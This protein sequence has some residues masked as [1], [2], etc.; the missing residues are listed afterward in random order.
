MNLHFSWESSKQYEACWLQAVLWERL[1]F[2]K[3]EAVV[4]TEVLSLIGMEESA[5]HA[6]QLYLPL[7][8]RDWT[9]MHHQGV[10]SKAGLL[11]AAALTQSSLE[12]GVT[13]FQPLSDAGAAALWS[14][15]EQVAA[16][17]S[18]PGQVSLQKAHVRRLL[19]QLQLK[20][21]GLLG[22][23]ISHSCWASTM[24]CYRLTVLV[25]KH[26]S[27]LLVCIVYSVGS[28][29]AGSK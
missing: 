26:K 13:A 1:S 22:N 19:Q 27:T 4:K 24:L 8:R 10:L 12:G 14:S 9:T 16:F 17:C 15:W 6:H 5:L 3:T 21:A 2:Q 28:A 11:A 29:L 25:C 20:Q 18:I 7:Q 23:S